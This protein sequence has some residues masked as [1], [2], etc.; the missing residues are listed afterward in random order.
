VRTAS[1]Y[2]DFAKDEIG[3]KIPLF[4]KISYI[5]FILVLWVIG[6][7]V[8]ASLVTLMWFLDNY[9]WYEQLVF[10][11]FPIIFIAIAIFA[12]A[13][14]MAPINVARYIKKRLKE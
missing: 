2:F 8:F 10:V 14:Y 11:L 13:Y 6:L 3:I 9:Q 5:Y 12:A 7:M 4:D 1:K